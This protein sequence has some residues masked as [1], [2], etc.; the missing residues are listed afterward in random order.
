MDN[1]IYLLEVALKP[2]T[3]S[4]SREQLR[5]TVKDL[6]YGCT[7]QILTYR[8]LETDRFI[9][10]SKVEDFSHLIVQAA[11][12]RDLYDGLDEYFFADNLGDYQG[13]SE[14][15]REVVIKNLPPVLQIQVQV[16]APAGLRRE[17]SSV[18]SRYPYS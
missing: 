11:E 14:A 7:E 2:L 12:G 16:R 1:A 5:D 4:D 10:T 8:D 17:F 9:T 6:F 15:V 3:L 18:N 13:G